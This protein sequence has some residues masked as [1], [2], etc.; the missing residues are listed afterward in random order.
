MMC[1]VGVQ[2]GSIVAGLVTSPV[3][4][5][6]SLARS[7]V[8]SA[9]SPY[10]PFVYD[11][12]LSYAHAAD[13]LIRK[14]RTP[15]GAAIADGATLAAELRSVVPDDAFASGFGGFQSGSNDPV[16]YRYG[17]FNIGTFGVPG[18]SG[19]TVRIGDYVGGNVILNG[20]GVVV[21]NGNSVDFIV[22]PMLAI[23]FLL[24]TRSDFS[25]RALATIEVALA[26]VAASHLF[27]N[28]SGG[29]V[30]AIRVAVFAHAGEPARIAAG[31]A[32]LANLSHALGFVGGLTSAETASMLPMAT[33]MGIPLLS[34]TATNTALAT[35]SSAA[36]FQR[37]V[38]PDSVQAARLV[39][40]VH[41][42]QWNTVTV[43]YDEQDPYALGLLASFSSAAA[44]LGVS[45]CP[46]HGLAGVDAL[47]Q[48]DG[49]SSALDAC[50]TL[51]VVLFA[52]QPAACTLMAAA[53]TQGVM[54]NA[55]GHEWVGVDGWLTT[56]I[57][58]DSTCIGCAA[59]AGNASVGAIGV[60]PSMGRSAELLASIA[61][62]SVLPQSGWV[63]AA[64]SGADAI[65]SVHAWRVAQQLLAPPIGLPSWADGAIYDAVWA[66]AH[67]AASMISDRQVLSY[68]SAINY[69]NRV[70]FNGVRVAVSFSDASS[71]T[72]GTGFQAMNANDGPL[73]ATYDILNC[74][75]TSGVGLS[76]G[77]MSGL[78][79]VD[80]SQCPAGA[81]RGT[82]GACVKCPINTWKSTV[83]DNACTPCAS[84]GKLLM[85]T[86]AVAGAKHWSA[87]KCPAGV[88]ADSTSMVTPG[89]WACS[90]CPEGMYVLLCFVL[91]NLYDAC[92]CA[93]H[94]CSIRSSV[95]SNKP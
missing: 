21:A 27:Q 53:A 1:R 51:I 81:T 47:Q 65:S 62:Q 71:S 86:M 91:R 3:A 2:A 29:P 88:L 95:V 94:A 37:M 66:Y 33:A 40:L 82:D 41:R 64:A 26:D 50:D 57:A 67:A 42:L 76:V 6:S 38:P 83:G 70:S 90:V 75:D 73:A 17:V 77:L 92:K 54:G 79:I 5:N 10:V 43:V 36:V 89:G 69:I 9:S 39:D 78:G 22:A 31:V 85:T 8:G 61:G 16:N 18:S 45:L 24:D 84:S 80:V 60:A 55:T 13:R 25:Q 12:V 52:N 49:L 59:A 35:Q 63:D 44:A 14:L 11:A 46:A 58:C 7:L 48:P 93:R 30:T 74:N 32:A 20:K 15:N 72:T 56:P 87:C 28:A 4:P 23:G 19:N 68:S 34:P